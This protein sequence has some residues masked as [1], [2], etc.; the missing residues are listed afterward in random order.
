MIWMDVDVALGEV[1]VNYM[2]LLDDTDFKTIEDAV[3]FNQAGL[4]LFWN[5]VTTAGA[6][7]CTAVTPT[8]AGDYDWTDQ[9]TSG[10]YAIEMP[11]SGGASINNDTEGFGWFTGKATGVLPWAGPII[12]FRAAALNNSLIDAGTTG[13]LAPTT[14]A[15]TL[16]VSAA[17]NAGIDWANVENPTASL[18]LTTT[19]LGAV[20]TVAGN[21]V[22]SAG[23]VVGT[24]GAVGA[25]GITAASFAANAITAAKLDPDVTT[26]LQAG[27]ATS[28]AQATAQTSLDAIDAKTTNLPSDPADQSLIIAA[29]NA[30][31]AILGTPAGASVSVDM[32]AL[33]AVADAV[34]VVTDQLVAAQA[35]PTGVPS[36]NPTPLV[37]LA[38]LHQALRNRIDVDANT[39][40]KTFYDDNNAA[41]WEKDFTDV[42]GVYSE[43]EANAP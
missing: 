20:T 31:L 34:K 36:A 4:A 17:G 14:A 43:S 13:L 38:R 25:G 7:T 18:S 9:G 42:G 16:D 21:V 2:P 40:K 23:S 22:G 24:V 27:L 35:E 8:S 5:F 3:V 26:E 12:G 37:K 28:A 33:K 39:G 32:A 1:P 19:L 30:I 15:R 10:M 11:A 41:L 6:Q 29:T